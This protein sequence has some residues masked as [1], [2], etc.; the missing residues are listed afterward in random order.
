ML[1]L[2]IG[3]VVVGLVLYLLNQ[4]VPMAAPVKTILNV[5]VVLLLILWVLAA[6]GLIGTTGVVPRVTVRP[7]R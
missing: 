1:T 3:L 7:L 2:I 5:V 4:Y 6:F